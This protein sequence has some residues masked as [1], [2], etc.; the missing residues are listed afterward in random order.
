MSEFPH[1][2]WMFW[3]KGFE[4]LPEECLACYNSYKINNPEWD[5]NVLDDN[6]LSTYID[7]NELCI[8]N[9][10]KSNNVKIAHIS[11]VIRICLLKKYGG[12]WADVTTFC[13]RNL[14]EWISEYNNKELLFFSDNNNIENIS[15]W[16]F[17]AKKNSKIISIFYDNYLIFWKNNSYMP[18]EDYFI[19][20]NLF[21]ELYYNNN[22]FKDLVNKTP[23]LDR[24]KAH[25]LQFLGLNKQLTNEFKNYIDNYIYDIPIYKLN[26]R[27]QES[28]SLKKNTNAYY[29]FNK[30]NLFSYNNYMKSY[31]INYTQ[32]GGIDKNIEKAFKT[33]DVT[34]GR[35]YDF[36]T[37]GSGSNY[38]INSELLNFLSRWLKEN[39]IKSIV[40]VSSGHWRSG[41]QKEFDWNNI[42]YTGVDINKSVIL[43]NI[44][45]SKNANLNIKN[46]NFLHGDMTTQDLPPAEVLL[47]K[48]TIIHLPN[49]NVND[50]IKLNVLS[51]KYKYVLF[52]HDS[53]NIGDIQNNSIKDIEPEKFRGIDI[54]KNPFNLK[55]TTIYEGN[56]KIGTN[57]IIQLWKRQ[58]N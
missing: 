6:T 31:K 48:D 11:D 42:D 10:M 46:I 26:G 50:F 20:H 32:I 23:K 24:V 17:C 54:T 53:P 13:S 35:E 39:N 44:E 7:D 4:N 33:Y 25:H 29:L 45:F 14:D 18:Y 49:K 57:K 16:W 40:E 58:D 21:K 56:N 22:E 51:K 38:D 47:T 27:S 3:N 37:S 19:F 34:I 5:I 1:I 43:D 9:K 15:N 55:A 28:I 52:S 41:W 12:I 30:L 8:I 36:S 2:I